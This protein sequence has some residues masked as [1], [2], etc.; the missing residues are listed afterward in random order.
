MT[1][2]SLSFSLS[3]LSRALSRAARSLFTYAGP[4]GK[5]RRLQTSPIHRPDDGA[6]MN[7]DGIEFYP[8]PVNKLTHDLLVAVEKLLK[9]K[10]NHPEGKAF[11]LP[12]FVEVAQTKC[13]DCIL[14][15]AGGGYFRLGVP[16]D[17]TCTCFKCGQ[18]LD[19]DVRTNTHLTRG[20]MRHVVARMGQSKYSRSF[21][22]LYSI[23]SCVFLIFFSPFFLVCFL[24]SPSLN[25]S[26][27]VLM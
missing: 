8:T 14:L 15:R 5:R 10:N 3:A 24:G 9:A 12:A 18:L 17:G 11:I 22:L 2:F 23:F 4:A 19:F 6:A 27:R 20:K 21:V 7:Y 26:C 25:V 13:V 16:K 1:A